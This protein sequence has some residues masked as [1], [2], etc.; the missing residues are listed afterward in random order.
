MKNIENDEEN[1]KDNKNIKS[2]IEKLNGK[3]LRA[4]FN[5]INGLDYLKELVNSCNNNK[6]KDMAVEYLNAGGNILELLR[7]LDSADMKNIGSA[8]TVF[9]AIRIML[10]K[11][12]Y[13]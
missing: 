5:S 13:I 4:V 10:I 7:L 11:Y 2:K 9:S 1:V 12:V 6:D 3:S 8:T